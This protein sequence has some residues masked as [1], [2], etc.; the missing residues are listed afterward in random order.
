ME[1]EILKIIEPSYNSHDKMKEAAHEITQ[2]ITGFIE[3]T[4][5]DNNVKTTME[6]SNNRVT[7]WWVHLPDLNWRRLNFNDLYL[8]YIENVL[9][10]AK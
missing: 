7:E 5:R 2:H 4:H 3:W 8:Y 10:K 1:E 9:N 6:S